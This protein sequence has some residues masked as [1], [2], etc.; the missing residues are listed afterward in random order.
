MIY[1]SPAEKHKR[2]WLNCQSPSEFISPASQFSRSGASHK[3]TAEMCCSRPSVAQ[4]PERSFC[5]GTNLI[6]GSFEGFCRA[7]SLLLRYNYHG[8][9]GRHARGCGSVIISFLR[10]LLCLEWSSESSPGRVCGGHTRERKR[11]R[12]NP[13]SSLRRCLC[14]AHLRIFTHLTEALQP[15]DTYCSSHTHMLWGGRWKNTYVDGRT[16]RVCVSYR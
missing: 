3:S 2:V 15:F 7:D 4:T 12:M 1:G 11:E 9:R 8:S 13:F 16:M 14:N 10:G 6:P 5:I